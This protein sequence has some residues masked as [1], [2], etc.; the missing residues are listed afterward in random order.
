MAL[1]FSLENINE[2]CPHSQHEFANQGSFEFSNGKLDID[3]SCF[4]K[5][6]SSGEIFDMNNNNNSQEFLLFTETRPKE[7]NVEASA[8]SFG[9]RDT[10]DNVFWLFND[11]EFNFTTPKYSTEDIIQDSM[12]LRKRTSISTLSEFKTTEVA[13]ILEPCRLI[14]PRKKFVKGVGCSCG[15]S[16]CLRLHCKCFNAQNYCGPSCGCVECY[17]THEFE[18]ERRFVI[19]KTKSIF[20][21]AFEPKLVQASNNVKINSQGCRCKTGCQ[22]KYC[23]CFRNSV[24]CSPICKCIACKNTRIEINPEEVRQHF[25]PALR[26]KDRI[27]ILSPYENKSKRVVKELEEDSR[28][29][30]D[31]D[32]RIELKKCVIAYRGYKKDRS[33]SSLLECSPSFNNF[34]R[35]PN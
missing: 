7:P 2:S 25:E 23:D 31:F 30:D 34:T 26:S 14:E 28:E 5:K 1:N 4:D 3:S 20:S 9:R 27:L 35:K 6:G 33:N 16:R 8:V 12:L 22:K 29:T 18:D 10:I 19:N 32:Y 17:N 15:K 24:G 21:K 13:K 11:C